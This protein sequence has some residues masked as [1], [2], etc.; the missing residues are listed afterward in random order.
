[1][2]PARALEAGV[3]VPHFRVRTIDGGDAA[4][5]DI[6]QRK[7]LLLVLLPAEAGASG[8]GYR[9]AL[10]EHL[11]DLTAHDTAVIVTR[12]AVAGA[13]RPGIIVADRWGEIYFVTGGPPDRLPAPADLV[14]WLRFMQVQ[15]PE[16]QGETR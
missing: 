9:A 12:D 16:C 15:C 4:Y 10:D 3:Q 13:P 1:M 5:A 14:D 11:P 8:D 6:W 7:N 2:H